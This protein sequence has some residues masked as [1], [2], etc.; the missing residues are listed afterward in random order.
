MIKEGAGREEIRARAGEHA[1]KDARH[2]GAG[3][4]L[5]P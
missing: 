2:N 5:Y 4:T 1:G 3:V